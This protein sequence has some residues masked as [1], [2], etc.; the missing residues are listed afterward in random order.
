MNTVEYYNPDT[1]IWGFTESMTEAKIGMATAGY[2]G[3]L[4][5]VGGFYETMNDKIVL[6][7]VEC[8]NPRTNK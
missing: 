2:H 3:L 7:T 1:D 6:D 5:V 4:Y 8:Y